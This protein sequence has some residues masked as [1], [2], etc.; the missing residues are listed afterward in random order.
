MVTRRTAG[1]GMITTITLEVHL[2]LS[3][4]TKLFSSLPAAAYSPSDGSHV[5]IPPGVLPTP[6]RQ[7]VEL[8]L[9]LALALH[10]EIAG[11]SRW[12]RLHEYGPDVPRGYRIAQTDDPLARGGWFTAAGQRVHVSAVRLAED[13]GEPGAPQRAGD[14]RLEILLA[15]TALEHALETLPAYLQALRAIAAASTA[16]EPGSNASTC[17]LHFT[18][19]FGAED[20]AGG[21]RQLRVGCLAGQIQRAVMLALKLRA[22]SRPRSLRLDDAGYRLVSDG[23][24]HVQRFSFHD[25]DLP[26]LRLDPAWIEQLRAECR[27]G[28]SSL[29]KAR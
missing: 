1:G 8:A 23:A 5:V 14:P 19:R 25:P 15:P 2:R 6:N 28:T 16:V 26:P 18:T 10:A 12:V 7:A 13:A 21:I 22:S 3:T 11:T 24:P 4:R 29:C 17:F 20:R 9:R 27:F